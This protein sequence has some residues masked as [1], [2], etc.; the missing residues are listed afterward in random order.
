LGSLSYAFFSAVNDG[1]GV[2]AGNQE[3]SF[4]FGFRGGLVLGGIAAVLLSTTDMIDAPRAA[5]RY[6]EAHSIADPHPS[7]RKKPTRPFPWSIYPNQHQSA[8]T[9]APP[10]R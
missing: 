7:K 2:F 8:P 5:R 10:S 4:G 1:S 3:G 9:S 6:N